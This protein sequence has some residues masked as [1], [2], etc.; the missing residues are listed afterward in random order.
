M[1]YL[2]IYQL[3][4]VKKHAV[5]LGEAPIVYWQYFIITSKLPVAISGLL[6]WWQ[7]F[8]YPIISTRMSMGI[9]LGKIFNSGLYE[10]NPCLLMLSACML[11]ILHFTHT[12]LEQFLP[13][14]SIQ[15][16]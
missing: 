2:F 8:L 4:F 7:K 1:F 16:V 13:I 11:T 15:E 12:A 14:L 6:G 10:L 9:N 3:S 5:I